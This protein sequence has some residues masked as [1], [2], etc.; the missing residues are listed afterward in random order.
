MARTNLN[1]GAT[2][3]AAANWGDGIGF[4]TNADLVV[5]GATSG[6]VAGLDQS[7]VATG[8]NSLIFSPTFSGN[9]GSEAAGNLKVDIDDVT[10]VWTSAATTKAKLVYA[11]AGGVCRIDAAGGSTKIENTFVDAPGGILLCMGGL[12]TYLNVYKGTVNVNA[13]VTLTDIYIDGPATVLIE[14]KAS[15]LSSM[16]MWSGNCTL[17]RPASTKIYLYGGTLTIDDDAAVATVAIE[18]NGGKLVHL[19]GGITTYTAN[20]GEYTSA[21]MRKSC[22]IGTRNRR[23]GFKFTDNSL[24]LTITTDTRYYPTDDR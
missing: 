6:I 9:V 8:I 20:A 7:A 17:K 13:S 19:A 14:A 3:F 24:F 4:A 22:T 1:D 2:S 16:Y 5:S 18:Q 15:A 21:S 23:R 10:G 11:A 12:W